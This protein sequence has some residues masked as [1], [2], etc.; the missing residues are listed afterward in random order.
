MVQPTGELVPPAVIHILGPNIHTKVFF[1]GGK[2]NE[3]FTIF[4]IQHYNL[5]GASR[6]TLGFNLYAL[7]YMKV[8]CRDAWK[9]NVY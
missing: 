7:S 4:E 3:F 2:T 6:M 9:M 8:I 1:W 5:S